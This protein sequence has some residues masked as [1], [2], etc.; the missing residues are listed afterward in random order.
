MSESG[1]IAGELRRACDRDP[2]RVLF[3][4]DETARTAADTER[5]VTAL[6]T[7][8]QA[9]G[10]GR[11]DALALYAPNSV[12]WVDLWFA[13]MQ[14]GALVVPVNTAFRGDFLVH[15]LKDAEVTVLAAPAALLEN[16]AQVSAR[17]PDLTRIIVLDGEAP[18]SV[19]DLE[20]I[21]L[22]DVYDAGMGGAPP[23]GG[24]RWDEPAA[25]FYTSGTTGP[26]K[27]ALTSQQYLLGGAAA[28][29]DAQA[30]G[31]ADTLFGAMPLFH[32][33]GALG[34]VLTTLV[35]GA[36]GILDSTFSVSNCWPRVRAHGVTVFVGV[37][38]MVM[39]LL[40]LPP[41]PSD[42]EL[43]IRLISAA[44]IPP[45]LLGVIEARYTCKVRGVYGMTEAFPVCMQRYDEPAVPGS[46]GAPG[47]QFELRVVDDQDCD[48]GPGEAGE[49]IVRPR[50]PQGIFSG[51]HN[52]PDETLAQ[53]KNLWFHTGDLARIGEGGNV[54]FVDRKK[55]AIR[56]RGENIS[57]FE[58][59]RAVLKHSDVAECAAHA[60][61]SPVGE[62]DVKVVVVVRAGRDLDPA[63]LLEHCRCELPRFAVP[64]YL[65]FVEAL[66]KSVTGRVQKAKLRARP[67]SDATWDAE[68]QAKEP[69]A[70]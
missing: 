41:D 44:P 69:T 2:D 46:A 13:A 68:R 49:I 11:R 29:A 17:L 43:P 20:V 32:V 38:P 47:P 27:G 18:R 15:P 12:E 67:L 25:I 34:I 5:Q 8:L 28:L 61:P 9:L 60:V 39:M 3:R 10:I 65:E 4:F 59:E 19:Q 50:Q 70:R 33:G 62:D 63:A 54:F 26:S 36:S 51:Y 22:E 64:R 45:E 31:P 48:V 21:S 66:P 52:R 40:S 30:I 53:L 6:A 16:V 23:G 37:G 24:F 35:S 57:S 7:G 1:T 14:V 55:D 56:R 58:V 42:A